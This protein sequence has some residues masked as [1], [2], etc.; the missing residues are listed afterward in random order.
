MLNVF[1]FGMCVG[2]HDFTCCSCWRNSFIWL[3]V[4]VTRRVEHQCILLLLLLD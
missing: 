2:S 3:P 4:H 1:G